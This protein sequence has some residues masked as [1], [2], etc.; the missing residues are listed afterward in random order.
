M[1]DH[2]MPERYCLGR[3]HE[4]KVT[5]ITNIHITQLSHEA[6]QNIVCW[7]KSLELIQW[8]VK[9]E[10]SFKYLCLKKKSVCLVISSSLHSPGA[11]NPNTRRSCKF[12]FLDSYPK[13]R[14][15]CL[16][17]IFLFSPVSLP[18][19]TLFRMMACPTLQ[20]ES[21]WAKMVFS[22]LCSL[23]L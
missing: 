20:S 18:A 4:T 17:P 19:L 8:T 21:Y 7:K 14:G 6:E 23:V 22:F 12:V 11:L 9:L 16:S 13:L 5:L 1:K 15:S 10:H 2:L 3:V